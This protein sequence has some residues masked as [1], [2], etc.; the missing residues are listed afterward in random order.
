MDD[1][2]DAI[3]DACSDLIAGTIGL[4]GEGVARLWRRLRGRR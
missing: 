3:V 1:V 2:V 4:V